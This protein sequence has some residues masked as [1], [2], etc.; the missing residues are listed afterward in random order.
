MAI[1]AEMVIMVAALKELFVLIMM[2]VQ[3]RA[4]VA[5]SK[6]V[7]VLKGLPVTRTSQGQLLVAKSPIV[8][9]IMEIVKIIRYKILK[10]QKSFQL[11]SF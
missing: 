9:L 6:T 10:N 5:Q 4:V 1:I 7:V 11:P 8:P 2:M 3:S